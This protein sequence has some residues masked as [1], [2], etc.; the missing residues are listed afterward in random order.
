MVAQ[1]QAPEQAFESDLNSITQAISLNDFIQQYVRKYFN[2]CRLFCLFTENSLRHIA[3]LIIDSEF[4]CKRYDVWPM[5]PIEF[6]DTDIDYD[7][8]PSIL[9]YPDGTY[10]IQ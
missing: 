5:H 2:N 4:N 10:K 3:M 8:K 1:T 6:S 9:V 7:N